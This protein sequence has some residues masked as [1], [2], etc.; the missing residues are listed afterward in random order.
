MTAEV[1][2]KIHLDRA[3]I[4]ASL[5]F[6]RASNKNHLVSACLTYSPLGWLIGSLCIY[7]AYFMHIPSDTAS[8]Y[9]MHKVYIPSDRPGKIR[10]RP[11]KWDPKLLK[12]HPNSTQMNQNVCQMPSSRPL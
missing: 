1:T 9:F 4:E 3:I 7:Y 11:P 8:I 12:G 10:S 6:D 5:L 2:M